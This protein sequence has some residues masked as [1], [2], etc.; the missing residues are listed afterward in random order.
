M[1]IVT[2]NLSNL[3]FYTM[4]NFIKFCIKHN[5]NTEKLNDIL[6]DFFTSNKDL[7]FEIEEK[8]ITLFLLSYDHENY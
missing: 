5:I 6:I 3:P 1:G 4:N 8:Y 2:V 7:E